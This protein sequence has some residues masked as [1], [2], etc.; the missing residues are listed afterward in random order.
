MTDDANI[1]LDLTSLQ[2][3]QDKIARAGEFH[4]IHW[5]II[6]GSALLT[7]YAS[8]LSKTEGEQRA[9]AHYNE[10]THRIIEL[11]QERM[12]KYEVALHS[13][14]SVIKANGNYTNYDHWKAFSRALKIETRYPGINGI[15]VIYNIKP[16][17][18]EAYL[19]AERLVRP[20]YALHPPHEQ[21]EYWPITYIEPEESNAK[22]VG[23]D[24]AHEHNRYAAILKARDTGLPQVT[25]PI[26][27]VQD[28]MKTPGFLFYLPFYR[29]AHVDT[30]EARRDHIIGAVYAP[31]IFSKLMD[32]TLRKESR[33]V[34]IKITDGDFALYDEFTASLP[35][36][37]SNPIYSSVISVNM[38]GRLWDF[39]FQT[40]QSFRDYIDN[41]KPLFILIGGG[42]IE[43]LLIC[44]FMI[45]SRSNRKALSF[46]ARMTEG[47]KS[48]AQSLEAANAELEEFA[49]RTSHDLRSPLISARKLI[50]ISVQ[51]IDDSEADM[52]KKSLSLAEDALLNL[53]KLVRNILDLTQNTYMEEETQ[54]INL[55]QNIE[56]VL[57]KLEH[58]EH[59][60]R[61]TIN[62]NVAEDAILDSKPLRLQTI[63]ENLVS[64]A[65][66]YQDLDE[67]YPFLN[68]SYN[69]ADDKSTLVFEDNG[70]G[71]PEDQRDNIFQ[72]FKRFHPRT[73]YGS[74][75]G[76]YMIKKSIDQIG[77]NI[78][79]SPR[80]KGTCFTVEFTQKI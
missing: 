59:F 17:H 16:Q 49:Y 41:S 1:D 11:V 40:T 3:E 30:V 25:G 26:I 37:D 15:G 18:L 39:H 58:M 52:A 79:Y 78:L 44:I 12:D 5:I 19:Q 73:S 22:A 7:I 32:G 64:N 29:D 54:S 36:F 50:Q 60:E 65:I 35:D 63:I 24:M 33:T 38:Y 75:L 69:D 68:I 23:L 51:A 46:A 72:M 42:F 31:F 14:V 62:I 10:Q 4:I 80:D 67:E 21:T 74:G 55:R 28:Q 45:L 47:Y 13:G 34:N 61:L 70:L 77:A 53:E 57:R 27:L 2:A 66:K 20:S 6:L 43:T 8:L 9:L 56:N 48:K 71:I 76:L